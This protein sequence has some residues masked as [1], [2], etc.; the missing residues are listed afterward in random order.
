MHLTDTAYYMYITLAQKITVVDNLHMN[1]W[2]NVYHPR[3]GN[4]AEEQLCTLSNK[5]TI[6]RQVKYCKLWNFHD[7]MM[8]VMKSYHDYPV[9][10]NK[11]GWISYMYVGLQSQPPLSNANMSF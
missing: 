2:T 5:V 6:F 1:K 3:Q 9:H 10:I 11:L 7:A 8:M 4:I